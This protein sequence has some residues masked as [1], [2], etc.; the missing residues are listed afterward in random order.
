MKKSNR[1]IFANVAEGTHRGNITFLAGDPILT[2]QVL[3]ALQ[4]NVVHVADSDE[5]PIGVITDEAEAANNPVNVQLLGGESTAI[6]IAGAPIAAGSRVVSAADGKITALPFAAGT[7]LQVG[8]A[9]TSATAAGDGVEVL[10][11]IPV[12]IIGGSDFFDGDGS[13][14]NTA[15]SPTDGSST[16]P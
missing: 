13:E 1:I 9:L 10:T 3:V 4:D 15:N 7:Y 16:N 6:I 5:I 8:I 2:R 12:P 14:E 11:G